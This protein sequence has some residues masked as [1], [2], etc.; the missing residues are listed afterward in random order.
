[1]LSDASLINL[2][3]KDLLYNIFGSALIEYI[4]PGISF[5]FLLCGLLVV[6][7]FPYKKFGNNHE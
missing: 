7:S 4:I 6:V 2:G 5:A 1:M 3:I